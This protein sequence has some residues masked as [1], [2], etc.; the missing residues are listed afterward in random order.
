LGQ[1]LGCWLGDPLASL[2][3]QAQPELVEV[4]ARFTQW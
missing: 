1:W 2:K 3:L 4:T